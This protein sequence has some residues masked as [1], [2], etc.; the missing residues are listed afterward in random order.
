MRCWRRD[1][2]PVLLQ[3]VGAF[4]SIL[5][6]LSSMLSA[7]RLLHIFVR[8]M[9]FVEVPSMTLKPVRTSSSLSMQRTER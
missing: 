3:L 9:F 4:L 1:G 7:G 8:G 6:M 5:K 2:V